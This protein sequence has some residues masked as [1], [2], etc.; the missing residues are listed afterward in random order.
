MDNQQLIRVSVSRGSTS[1]EE[2]P[3]LVLEVRRS[4][5]VGETKAMLH[6]L[7]S[8]V[9]VEEL[10]FNGERVDDSRILSSF[11]ES[12]EEALIFTAERRTLEVRTAKRRRRCSFSKCNSL[13]LRGVGDCQ[14]CAGHFCSR[15][16]L[17]EQHKCTG[18]QGCK[19][20]LHE[21]NALK[22]QQQQTLPNKV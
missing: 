18:L 15:H 19:Q 9:A 2:I 17:M 22:L 5:T 11:P 12:D 20:Q 7:D 13:P 1:N 4:Q 8:A 16:R 21:R 6:E 3:P 10:A 14:N